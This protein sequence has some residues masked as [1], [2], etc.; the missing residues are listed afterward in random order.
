MART[1]EDLLHVPAMI[2]AMR[3]EPELA[4]SLVNEVKAILSLAQNKL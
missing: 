2:K 3:G 1:L 4:K